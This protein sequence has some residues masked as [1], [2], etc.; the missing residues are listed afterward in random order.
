MLTAASPLQLEAR[1]ALNEAVCAELRSRILELWDRLQVP[2]EER[3]AVAPHMTG[4]RART[5]REVRKPACLWGRAGC[6][7]LVA[8][9]GGRTQHSIL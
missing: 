4:S 2:A 8:Q 1:Q 9:A 3:D 6:L 7:V 5:R